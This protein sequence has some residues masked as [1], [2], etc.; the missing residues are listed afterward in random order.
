MGRIV[1]WGSG[2]HLYRH[3]RT[4]PLSDRDSIPSGRGFLRRGGSPA[5]EVERQE[6]GE[7]CPAPRESGEESTGGEQDRPQV[8]AL[9]GMLHIATH[10]C[11]MRPTVSCNQELVI[12]GI[13]FP[14][15]TPDPE[16]VLIEAA[17]ADPASS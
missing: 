16:P 13:D 9:Q 14:R 4:S 15:A 11:T 6:P 2:G 10:P 12:W 8:L 17:V 1:C 7:G 3:C 5:Q